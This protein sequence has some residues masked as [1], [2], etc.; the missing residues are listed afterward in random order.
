LRTWQEASGN[1][2][3]AI[4]S[5]TLTA[6]GS[7]LY[8][9]TVADWSRKFISFNNTLTQRFRDA[10]YADSTALSIFVLMYVGYNAAPN[11]STHIMTYGAGDN[12]SMTAGSGGQQTFRYRQSGNISQA[13]GTYTGPTVHPVGFLRD[14]TGSR[15]R[16]YTLTEKLSPTFGSSTGTVFAYGA[17]NGNSATVSFGWSAE[18]VGPTAEFSDAQVKVIYQQLGWSPSWS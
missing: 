1:L 14:L 16:L 10:T 5:K 3:D 15:A 6:G 8:Q 2:L 7:P 11:A 9:Q 18:W 13:A 17:N 12:T 4:G